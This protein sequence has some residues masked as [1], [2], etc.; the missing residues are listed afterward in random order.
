MSKA[1][2]Q[3]EIATKNRFKSRSDTEKKELLNGKDKQSTQ[4]ATESAVR[5][6]KTYLFEKGYKELEAIPD[7]DLSNI[8]Y[9][10][11]SEVK[12]KKEDNYSVQTLK[13]IRAG[14]NR[15]FRKERALIQ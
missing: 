4:K 3:S 1:D 2:A 7:V 9:D 15:H 6:L 5:L 13:C 11:Y 10:F 14:L 8:L 12:P